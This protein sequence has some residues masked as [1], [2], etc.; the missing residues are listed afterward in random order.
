MA[1]DTELSAAGSRPVVTIRCGQPQRFTY[2]IVLQK[3]A[4]ETW[5]DG[6]PGEKILGGVFD[7]QHEAEASTTIDQEA[8]TLQGYSL[9]WVVFVKVPGGGSGQYTVSVEVSQDDNVVGGPFVSSGAVNDVET[10]SDFSDFTV[11]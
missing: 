7:Q 5:P 3:P 2:T 6:N 4:G 11:T 8:N 1:Q 9:Q 10:V